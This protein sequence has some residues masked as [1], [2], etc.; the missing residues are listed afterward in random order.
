M[1]SLDVNH[2]ALYIMGAPSVKSTDKKLRRETLNSLLTT[3]QWKQPMERQYWI[4]GGW[5]PGNFKDFYE[6]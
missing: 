5:L 6:L 4:T 1:P 3:E 2:K